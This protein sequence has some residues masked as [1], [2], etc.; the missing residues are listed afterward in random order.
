MIIKKA[1]AV[2]LVTAG[3]AVVPVSGQPD[4]SN[5]ATGDEIR[6]TAG[7]SVLSAF[8]DSIRL[9]Y[10]Q[11]EWGRVVFA[12]GKTSDVHLFNYD[13]LLEDILVIRPQGDTVV[14]DDPGL[15]QHVECRNTT[16]LRASDFRSPNQHK[17]YFEIVGEGDGL[18]LG[19]RNAYLFVNK[20]QRV[21][22]GFCSYADYCVSATTRR[23]TGRGNVPNVDFIWKK[24]SLYY[25]VDK[26]GK[27]FRFDK[28]FLH[29]FYPQYRELI[30]NYLKE[31]P[32]SFQ[33]GA[34]IE[35]LFVFCTKLRS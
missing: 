8:P 4:G 20:K 11:F 31:A 28:S 22:P 2:L 29:T 27:S 12:D 5:A 19:L 25:V 32:N 21:D 23:N 6:V 7:T 24:F 16:F 17:P 1:I 34:D 14:F 35:K 9:R 10:K 3:F 26:G 33:S 30:D 18:L 15:I 13:L